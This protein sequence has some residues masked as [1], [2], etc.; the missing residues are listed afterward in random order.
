METKIVETRHGRMKTIVGDKWV[1]KCLQDLGEYSEDEF[2]MMSTY[3]DLI[4]AYQP[5]RRVEIV[6]AGTY[7]GD[8]TV[9][10]SRIV[11]KIYAFEPQP[12]IAELLRENL[13]MNGVTNV[14]VY[15]LALADK[16]GT[17]LMDPAQDPDSP[18]SKMIG[19]AQGIEV[20][21]AR[22]DDLDLNPIFIKADV[23]GMEVPLLAGAQETIKR[24]SPILFMECDTITTPNMPTLN[25]VYAY[26]GYSQHKFIFPLYR[27]GNFNNLKENTFGSTASFMLLG[28]PPTGGVKVEI[29]T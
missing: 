2:Q 23:E 9:P 19:A 27:P 8:L 24:C 6:E 16:S 18:G 13:E 7:I 25:D 10:L 1:S 29:A 21:M 4:K 20:R 15:E 3:L 14:E 28:I 22:L 11:D 5:N 26:F 12:E 17:A